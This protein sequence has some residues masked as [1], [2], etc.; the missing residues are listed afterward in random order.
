MLMTEKR[1]AFTLMEILVVVFIIGLLA[2]LVGPRVI[3]LM[4][5]GKISATK[6]TLSAIKT[7]LVEYKQDIGHFPTAREGGLD[8]LVIMPN[9]KGNEK[10]EGPYLEAQEEVPL[11]SWGNEFEY[12]LPPVMYKTKYKYFEVISQGEEGED[13]PIHTGA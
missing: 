6:A 8:A 10:W 13:K 12:N 1:D 11:D 3:G 9:I 2:T 4:T 5:K 7:G